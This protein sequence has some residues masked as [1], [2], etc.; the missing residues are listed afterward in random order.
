MKPSPA[1]NDTDS[2]RFYLVLAEAADPQAL[3]ANFDALC[4]RDDLYIVY[5][6][7]TR[8][9]VY[10]A[11]RDLTAPQAL[12][13]APLAGHPKFRGMPA[14]ALKWLKQRSND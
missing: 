13:A 14:G 4:L 7:M 9:E 11:V 6:S 1:M 12:M 5:S 2:P 8:S 3:Q 10:H